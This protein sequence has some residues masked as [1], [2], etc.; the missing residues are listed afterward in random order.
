MTTNGTVWSNRDFLG[1]KFSTFGLSGL[2]GIVYFFSSQLQQIPIGN[3][4]AEC[5]A[6]LL[7]WPARSRRPSVSTTQASTVGEKHPVFKEKV[8][9]W[10]NLSD[11]LSW[12]LRCNM[13]DRRL[14]SIFRS[15]QPLFLEFF[16]KIFHEKFSEQPQRLHLSPVTIVHKLRLW[17]KIVFPLQLLHN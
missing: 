14:N 16:N 7:H 8:L 10:V 15:I 17:R 3:F 12:I 6:S 11:F 5:T 1:I 13:A 2:L 4:L 9:G